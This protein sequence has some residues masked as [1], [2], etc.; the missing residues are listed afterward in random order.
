MPVDRIVASPHWEWWLVFYFYLGGIAAGAY[1]MAAL[2]ELIGSE[3]DRELA[4]VAYYLAFPLVAICGILL[5]L[6]LGRPERFWH[7]LIQSETFWPMFKYWSPMSVGSWALFI[8]GGLSFLSFLGVLAEDRRFGLG[9]FS[10]LARWLHRGP[11]GLG[12]ELL[13]AGVGFFIASYTGAL[14]TATN[15][16]FWSDSPLIGALFLASAAS[17][18]IATMLLLRRRS[19]SRGS[20]ERLETADSLAIGLEL[21]LIG[22]FFVS[23]GALAMPLIRSRFGLLLL[24]GTGLLGLLLPLALRFMPRLR[25]G[26]NMVLPAIL[27]LIGGFIL[28]YS[29]L[30]A[31][32]ELTIAGR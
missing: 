18:G 16:P 32:Q 24:I 12:F 10:N 23:L 30:M 28:R 26:Q 14:L 5:I 29:I 8:F 15:Q 4:K 9:R 31:G 19:T 17:T 6:D 25:G 7:M 2:I 22:A 1:F 11:I 27:V 3:E 13:A 20:L 21:L